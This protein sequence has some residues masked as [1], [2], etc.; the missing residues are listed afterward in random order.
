MAVGLAALTR[1]AGTK[2]LDRWGLRDR[3][4]RVVFRATRT[5]FRTAGAAGRRFKAA[6]RSHPV[7]LPASRDPGLFD[8]TPTEEQR[9]VRD[10]MAEFAA[11]RLRPAAAEADEQACAPADLLAAGAELGLASIGIPEELGGAGTERSQLTSVLVAEQLGHGDLGLA[12]AC[13]APA[14]VGTALALWG[15][16]DQ[17]ATYLP[18][19]TGRHV[20]VAAL[21]VL[22]P[23]PLFD[24]F[25]L[26]TTARRTSGGFVLDGVKSLVPRAADA[27]LLVVAA[28]LD[29]EPALFVVEAD[30]LTVEAEPSMGLRAASTGRVLLNAVKLPGGALLGGHDSGRD[31]GRDRGRDGQQPDAAYRECVRLSRLAWCALAVGGAQAVL[32]FVIPYV[33]ERQA[34]GE[35]ISHRQAVAFTVADMG[36]ETDGMRLVT[37]RAASRATQGL[38]FAREVALARR[39]CVEHGMRIGSDGVQLLGGHGFVRDHPVQRWYRD[40]RA[41]GLMEG[42]LLA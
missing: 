12:V 34:F 10:T 31:S 17:Q 28:D 7:R 9:L 40:L 42:G 27:E 29:G 14:A 30:G 5:G 1:L 32:D 15:D 36:I 4:H 25:Q 38:P 6:T 8:L 37:Y 13:L 39:L 21:A 24:P 2:V 19:F 3:T 22:E 16:A 20:P 23:R 41:I 11:E 35:P 26:R 18:A 33:N